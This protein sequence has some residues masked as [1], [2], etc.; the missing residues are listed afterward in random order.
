MPKSGSDSPKENLR[1]STEEILHYFSQHRR[2]WND[3]YPSERWIFDRLAGPA[4]QMGRV[5][6]VGCATGGLGRALSERFALREYVGVDINRQVIEAAQQDQTHP[7]ASRRFIQG[8]I[9]EVEDLVGEGF[10]AVFSLSCAD[11]NVR[12]YDII[13]TCWQRVKEGGHLV[14]TLRLTPEASLTDFDQSFQYIFA[15]DRLPDKV[16]GLEKAAYVVLNV[17][18]VFRF[19]AD[20]KPRAFKITAYGYWGKPSATAVTA[21]DRLVFTSLSIRKGEKTDHDKDLGC[22]LNLPLDLLLVSKDN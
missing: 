19:L 16:E 15:G 8:D 6:D 18:E 13:Q 4:K 5:L 2:C 14:L 7:V 20:L 17:W 11:W 3:F 10:D 9:L 22:E 12:T 21:F 1:Y